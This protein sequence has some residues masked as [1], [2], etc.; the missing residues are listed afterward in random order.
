VTLTWTSVSG[1]AT[2]NVSRGTT[3][4]GPYTVVVSG[5]SA[6]SYKDSPPVPSNGSATFYYV[7]RANTGSCNSPYSPEATA[8][9]TSARMDAA[10]DSARD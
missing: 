7:V 1:A 5:L 10:A 4:G 6:T 9:V 2:Y 3:K 8:T